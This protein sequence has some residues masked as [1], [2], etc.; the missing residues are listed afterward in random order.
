MWTPALPNVIAVA[1]TDMDD[2]LSFFSSFGAQSVQI[3]APGTDQTFSTYPTPNVTNIL[4]HNFDSNPGGVEAMSSAAKQ[5]A[6][7]YG[8]G[9]Y[10]C[11]QKFDGQ[12]YRKLPEQYRLL[13]HWP[14]L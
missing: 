11:T 1:A 4:L 12:S 3:G 10:E 7:I 2:Q 14:G 8:C 5:I 6:E 9:V 13:G